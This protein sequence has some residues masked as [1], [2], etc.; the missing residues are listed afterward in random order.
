MIDLIPSPEPSAPRPQPTGCATCDQ[1]QAEMAIVQKSIARRR[2]LGA[3]LDL[4]FR[5]RHPELVEAL[6]GIGRAATRAP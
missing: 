4:H 6:T 2:T 5:S 1:L 3:M